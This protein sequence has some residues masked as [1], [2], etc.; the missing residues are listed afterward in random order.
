MG[1]GGMGEVEE[2]GV[3]G[4]GEGEVGLAEGGGVIGRGEIDEG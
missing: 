4:T 1:I 2:V 3:D